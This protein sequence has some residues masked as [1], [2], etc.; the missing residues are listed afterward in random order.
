MVTRSAL[1]VNQSRKAKERVCNRVISR[2]G[3]G[4]RLRAAR[5]AAPTPA[6][7]WVAWAI[8]PGSWI[9]RRPIHDR[10]RSSR[11]RAR[12]RGTT[13]ADALLCQGNA[14]ARRPVADDV[15]DGG[16]ARGQRGAR[17]DRGGPR[18][19]RRD[20]AHGSLPRLAAKA[21]PASINRRLE[22]KLSVRGV[23]PVAARP[24]GQRLA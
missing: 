21:T 13:R 15:D 17:H 5:T 4:D 10:G 3:P 2:G 11:G 16:C 22:A 8:I 20:D 23:R 19:R 1:N 9:R 14:R 12:C 7:S 24:S 6:G 18:D